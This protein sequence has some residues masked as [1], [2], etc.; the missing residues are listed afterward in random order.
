MKKLKKLKLHDVS[1]LNDNEMKNIVGGYDSGG[2][3]SG[4]CNGGGVDGNVKAC[5]GSCPD[6]TTYDMSSG[7]FSTRRQTCK[8][9]STT[10]YGGGKVTTIITCYCGPN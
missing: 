2:P 1:I 9:Q 7:Q 4:R 3:S 6:L 8:D 10:N 5:S